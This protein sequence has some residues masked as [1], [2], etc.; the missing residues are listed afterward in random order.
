MS[1]RGTER[2]TRSSRP[3]SKA[4]ASG[5]SEAPNA[6]NTSDS[7]SDSSEGFPA[8]KRRR[9]RKGYDQADAESE[10][11]EVLDDLDSDQ[12]LENRLRTPKKSKFSEKLEKMKHAKARRVLGTLES[13]EDNSEN[14]D[15]DDELDIIPGAVPP[16]GRISS[17]EIESDI[18]L[19]EDSDDEAAFIVEDTET[20]IALPL[21]FSMKSHSDLSHHFKII[22][23]LFVHIAVSKSKQR[24]K[25]V[26]RLH[27]DEYFHVPLSVM[28]RKLLAMRDSMVASSVWKPEF[29]GALDRHPIHNDIFMAYSVPIC[30]AC[31]ISGRVATIAMHLDG[32]AYDRDTFE[33][34]RKDDDS[35]SDDE[36]PSPRSFSLGKFCAR[37]AQIYHILTHWE[38]RHIL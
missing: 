25:L 9:I 35:D 6:L 36:E 13:D 37:R 24:A 18:E 3:R 29:R 11:E 7:S 17:P 28:R 31:R 2:R 26:K 33:P 16:N 22:C 12:I 5:S 32:E 21:E 10:E 27:K 23:Q 4:T 14:D 20:D 38:V 15:D 1:K 8:A 34:I 30:D 19:V